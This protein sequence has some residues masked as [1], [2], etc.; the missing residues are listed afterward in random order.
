MKKYI[1]IILLSL[2]LTLVANQH[3]SAQFPGMAE[4]LK[5]VEAEK[6]KVKRNSAESHRPK[7]SLEHKYIESNE[8]YII[9]PGTIIK[10]PRIKRTWP[11]NT[12]DVD[13]L[14]TFAE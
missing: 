3:V 12:G 9:E 2:C 11:K 7:D 10:A 4:M 1:R 14:D 5:Q 13:T 8:S 6:N